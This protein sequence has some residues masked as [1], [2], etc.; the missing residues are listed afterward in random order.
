MD[1]MKTRSNSY[2]HRLDWFARLWLWNA[3]SCGEERAR[4]RSGGGYK[5]KN[6]S[7]V[8]IEAKFLFTTGY[9]LTACG[10]GVGDWKIRWCCCSMK[11]EFCGS[12]YQPRGSRSQHKQRQH[13][14]W[15]VCVQFPTRDNSFDCFVCM[16]SPLAAVGEQLI[17]QLSRKWGL[18]TFNSFSNQTNRGR[19][20]TCA[21]NW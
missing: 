9:R 6:W 3:I 1:R 18:R 19:V 20:E 7:N 8:S 13:K 5:Y 17:C 21:I 15:R 11:N 16:S 4:E 12:C 14:P 10:V 2:T